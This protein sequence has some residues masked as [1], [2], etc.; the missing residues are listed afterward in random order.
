MEDQDLSK[1]SRPLVRRVSSPSNPSSSDCDGFEIIRRQIVALT[2][3]IGALLV[4]DIAQLPSSACYRL[5]AARVIGTDESG[6][7]IHGVFRMPR[8]L[9]HLGTHD[10]PEQYEEKTRETVGGVRTVLRKSK[11]V[12]KTVAHQYG[13][14]ELPMSNKE[15]KKQ[16]KAMPTDRRIQNRVAISSFL[17][18]RAIPAP[19]VLAFDA[20]VANAIHSPYTFERLPDGQRLEDVYSEMSL[21]DKLAIVDEMVE[22]LCRMESTRF[23]TAGRLSSASRPNTAAA[24]Q[25][26]AS[27]TSS[28]SEPE[29]KE[30]ISLYGPSAPKNEVNQIEISGFDAGVYGGGSSSSRNFGIIETKARTTP[31][32]IFAEQIANWIKYAER[33][34]PPDARI[35]QKYEDLV[36]I[37]EEMERHQFFDSAV[38]WPDAKARLPNVLAHPA[39]KPR[40]VLVRS[41]S[42]VESGEVAGRRISA[43]LGWDGALSLPPVLAREPLSWLWEFPDPYR[44]GAA[45]EDADDDGGRGEEQT[46]ASY[47]YTSEEDRHRIRCRFED[48]LVTALSSVD[49]G[50]TMAIYRQQAYG[51][52]KWLRK[53]F[54]FAVEGIKDP[55]DIAKFEHF[56]AEWESEKERLFR[57]D[58]L[59]D[60]KSERSGMSEDNSFRCV[61]IRDGDAGS[62]R[63]PSFV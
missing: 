61:G 28:Q 1:P 24:N 13:A 50:F 16:S 12:W 42:A 43:L 20:T 45:D 33:T 5:I 19:R 30:T 6:A 3:D 21:E 51:R 54:A 14:P 32:E 9:G 63:H 2:G 8:I 17:S 59:S 15:K 4:T 25:K 35:R 58:I 29:E 38:G 10:E 62:Q 11:R 57:G 34:R 40:N 23:R 39:L 7:S 48:S 37:I 55:E 22:I 36:T 56:R 31:K 41:K 60:E 26:P 18:L 46:L 52:G 49:D 44:S 47:R 53:V 27:T